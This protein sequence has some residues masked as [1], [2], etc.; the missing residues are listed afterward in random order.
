MLISL[1]K[2][3]DHFT[4][5]GNDILSIISDANVHI[6]KAGT[7]VNRLSIIWKTDLSVRS[8]WNFFQAVV[9][10]QRC[11]TQTITKCMKK[12]YMGPKQVY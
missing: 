7:S 3:V 6:E 11:T 9:L 5:C 1:K 12:R 10:L 2:V 8:K 4:F